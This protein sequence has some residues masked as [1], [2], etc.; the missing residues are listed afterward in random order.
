LTTFQIPHLLDSRSGQKLGLSEILARNLGWTGEVQSFT[1]AGVTIVNSGTSEI[2]KAVSE[3]AE[4]LSH[5]RGAEMRA[6]QG[7]W[8]QQFLARH[9]R[10]VMTRHGEI[11]AQMLLSSVAE[12]GR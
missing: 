1:D 10:D 9:H 4:L 12:L 3:Y 2:E 11:R 6:G 7:N 8:R 5:E